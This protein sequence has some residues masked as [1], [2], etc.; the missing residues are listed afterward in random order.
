MMM[1]LHPLEIVPCDDDDMSFMTNTLPNVSL[2]VPIRL[3]SHDFYDPQEGS[4]TNSNLTL[5]IMMYNQGLAHLLAH[6]QAKRWHNSTSLTALPAT[7][8]PHGQQQ[9]LLLRGAVVSLNCAQVMMDRHLTVIGTTECFERLGTLLVS[10]MTLKTM[11]WMSRYDN[12]TR[13]AEQA[14]ALL[15]HV[16]SDIHACEQQ[17]QQFNVNNPYNQ[18]TSSAA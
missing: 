2:F 15:T 7:T 1:P 8:P 13:E 6:V 5:A 17:L 11:M 9:D 14:R 18:A 3:R 12:Q 10:A 4:H 16:L